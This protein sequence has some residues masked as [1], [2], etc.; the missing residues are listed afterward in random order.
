MAWMRSLGML[1]RVPPREGAWSVVSGINGPGTFSCCHHC[2]LRWWA[3]F[4]AQTPRDTVR[5]EA[6]GSQAQ[7]WARWGV[8]WCVA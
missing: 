5:P 6:G 3:A 2:L 7:V 8:D 1:D 4:R